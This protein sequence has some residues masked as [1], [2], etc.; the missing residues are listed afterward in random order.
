MS[1]WKINYSDKARTE[2]GDIFD[3]IADD[4]HEPLIAKNL[5]QLIFKEI[6]SLETMPGRYRLYEDEPWHSYGLR[7]LP[8]KKYLIF[9]LAKEESQTVEIVRV[10]YGGRDIANQLNEKDVN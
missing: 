4:L 8:V 6:R 1:S 3:Y 2:I 7:I 9:Y 5:V 10:M